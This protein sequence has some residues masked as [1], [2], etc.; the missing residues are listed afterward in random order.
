MTKNNT[1]ESLYEEFELSKEEID[2]FRK[3]IKFIDIQQKGESF[4][5]YKSLKNILDEVIRND[6][7]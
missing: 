1:L 2:A 7:K 5:S 6:N 3:I 4:E